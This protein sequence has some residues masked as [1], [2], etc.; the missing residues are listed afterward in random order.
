MTPEVAETTSLP[1]LALRGQ[2]ARFAVIGFGSTV[3]HLGLLALLTAP[4][5]AQVANFTGLV[6]STVVNTAANRAWTFGV[7]GT[8]RMARHHLQA[9]VVFGITWATSSGALELLALVWPGASTLVTVA[10]VAVA[11]AASTV[12]RFLAMRSWIFRPRTGDSGREDVAL[13]RSDA[14]GA[15]HGSRRLSR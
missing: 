6:I 9:L 1:R 5:G 11:N 10:V 14:R 3:L 2:V 7:R 15:G 12:A 4:L 8:D 13:G